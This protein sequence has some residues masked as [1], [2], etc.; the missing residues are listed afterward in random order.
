MDKPTSSAIT[1]MLA[2]STG[3][4]IVILKVSPPLSFQERGRQ[5]D[6]NATGI[7]KSVKPMLRKAPEKGLTPASG[8]PMLC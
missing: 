6:V 1:F 8:M 5:E 7:N 4:G 2:R 3:F